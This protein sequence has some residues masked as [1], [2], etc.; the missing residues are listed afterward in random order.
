M[1]AFV[2]PAFERCYISLTYRRVLIAIW[3]FG[4]CLGLFAGVFV[5]YSFLSALRLSVNG[6]VSVELRE[7]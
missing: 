6:D 7:K 3:H 1:L 5:D 4:I 2:R